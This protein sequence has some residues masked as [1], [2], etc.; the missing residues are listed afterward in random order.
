VVVNLAERLGR[1]SVASRI[2]PRE[3]GRQDREQEEKDGAASMRWMLT[4]A[5]NQ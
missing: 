3:G 5:P 1:I 4:Q 2:L